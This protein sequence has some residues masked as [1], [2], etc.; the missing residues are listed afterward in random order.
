MP[1]ASTSLHGINHMKIPPRIKT[2][3]LILWL[4]DY[5]LWMKHSQV[6]KKR[7]NSILNDFTKLVSIMIPHIE[8]GLLQYELAI[9]SG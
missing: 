6:I 8:R 5:F 1:T 7:W 4:T 3:K 2:Q 9:H